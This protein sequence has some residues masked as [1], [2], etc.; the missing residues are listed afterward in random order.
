MKTRAEL[1]SLITT[2]INT[3]S[4]GEI[5]ATKV[6]NILDETVDSYVHKDD[7]D[8]TGGVPGLTLFKI[9]FRNVANTFTSFFTNSNTAARTYTFQNRN[10][11]IADD[12]DLA[13]KANLASPTFTG[14]VVL[15]S[16][17]SI[18]TVSATEISYLDGVSSSIQNQLNA[19]VNLNTLITAGIGNTFEVDAK[20]LIVAYST[21]TQGAL[22]ANKIYVDSIN[23]VNSTGRGNVNNPYLTPEYALSDIT[24][25][26]TITATT[27]NASATLTAVS[28]T[29]NIVIGQFITGAGI[30]YNSVVVSKTVDTIVLS[31][32]CTASAT[33]TATWWTVYELFL[34]GNFVFSSSWQKQGFFFNCATSNIVYSGVVF[35]LTASQIVPWIV[36]GGNWNGNH[37]NSK[38]LNN[39]SAFG[40]VAVFL[41]EPLSNI[42]IGTG[43]SFDWNQNGVSKYGAFILNC[44]NYKCLFGKVADLESAGF[45]SMNGYFY[46][47]LEGFRVRYGTFFSTGKIE[48]PSSVNALNATG[49]TVWQVESSVIGSVN[50]T[51]NTGVFN[52]SISGTTVSTAQN[53]SNS[54]H[55]TFNGAISCT[56]FNV[57]GFTKV[58]ACTR[59]NVVHTRD[60]LL[61]TCHIGNYTGSGTNPLTTATIWGSSGSG[62]TLGT[63]TLTGTVVLNILD[64]RYMI[65]GSS[66]MNIGSGCVVNNYG[67]YRGSL[68]CSGTLNNTGRMELWYAVTTS[69]TINNTNFISIDNSNGNENGTGTPCII[70]SGASGTYKQDGGK[71]IILRS[72]SKSGAIR[73]TASGQKVQLSGQAYI[74]VSNGLAPIQITS[75]T[76]TAQDI[77]DYSLI[78]NCAVGFRI[79]D[80]FTDT[81]YGTAYAPN[82]LKL[83]VKFED[84][85]NLL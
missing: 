28:S 41:F 10:G 54:A 83:G 59:S 77:E 63:I 67:Y 44:Q 73:K 29:A 18:D 35:P 79:A 55:F 51:S 33:I 5:T 20:G 31:Q 1:Y 58:N 13:L 19:K 75:N 53:D 7:K 49:S 27:T 26:G 8:A 80:T 34:N 69:G 9:N 6:R 22:Q 32:V 48:T 17:T 78:D 39:T 45:N 3:N 43:Y 61:L 15:P 16:T 38:V 84:T 36:R 72:D 14:T 85:T 76:G 62:F 57:A 24:N 42:T 56:T 52:G 66:A 50:L 71:L 65:N 46:A 23:G 64:S 2:D 4:N 30:P 70:L 74:K 25:T 81:T 12:T 21:V 11:T 68:V 82:L 40:S 37:A 60:D 47:L